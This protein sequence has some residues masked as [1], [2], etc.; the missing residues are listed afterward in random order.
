MY[1]YNKHKLTGRVRARPGWFGRMVMQVE[2]KVDTFSACPPPPACKD[3]VD[4]ESRMHKGSH[5]C[6][7]DATWFDAAAIFPVE[8]ANA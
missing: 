8:A 3:P 5:L 2:I 6:W 7:R 1:T 4:W